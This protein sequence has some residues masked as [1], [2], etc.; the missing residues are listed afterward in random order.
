MGI[1]EISQRD[2]TPGFC[3]NRIL[4]QMSLTDIWPLPMACVHLT[5][6]MEVT[7]S[8]R[9]LEGFTKIIK[10]VFFSGHRIISAHR[11]G[12]SRPQINILGS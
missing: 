5:L 4:K 1:G 12:I 8:L 7:T 11:I 10:N 6:D 3:N 9:A 2:C